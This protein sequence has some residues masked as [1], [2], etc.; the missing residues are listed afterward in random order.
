[1]EKDE[2]D[3]LNLPDHGI[4]TNNKFLNFFVSS[5]IGIWGFVVAAIVIG[6][7]IYTIFQ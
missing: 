1:M 7:L 5:P 3:G 4:Q 6:T 2:K